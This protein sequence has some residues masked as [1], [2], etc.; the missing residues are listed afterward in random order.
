[1]IKGIIFDLDQTLIDSSKLAELRD[2]RLW[3]RIYDLFHLTKINNGIEK[4]LEY[5]SSR[6]I[7]IAVVT[8][9]RREYAHKILAYH[10]IKF[11]VLI[12]FS[13]TSMHKP[14]T[15]PMLLAIKKLGISPN[16]CINIGD[17]DNDIVSGK[18]CGIFSIKIGKPV[19]SC[20][21]VVITNT[22]ELFEIIR[23]R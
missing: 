16:E 6:G 2:Q 12:G 23:L 4:T 17:S 18:N 10:H 14:D 11:D 20:P 22:D 9:S 1:M 8:N 7:K 15:E 21:D 19:M 13:D 3:Y 5:I